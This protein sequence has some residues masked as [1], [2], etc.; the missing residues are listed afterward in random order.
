MVL[1]VFMTNF[2]LPPM[3]AIGVKYYL[4]VVIMVVQDM[5]LV[6]EPSGVLRWFKTDSSHM[7]DDFYRIIG[8][9]WLENVYT[10]LDD[11]V[12]VIDECGKVKSNPQPFNPLASKLY[13]GWVRGCDPIVGPAIVCAIHDVD[14]DPDWVSLNSSELA[15]LSSY[16][17]VVIPNIEVT[18]D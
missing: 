2:H 9:D 1:L 6:I 7:I 17:G 16:L 10:V 14:G 13:G 11:I 12:I 4:G 5:F 3:P 15:T 18:Y 8:C